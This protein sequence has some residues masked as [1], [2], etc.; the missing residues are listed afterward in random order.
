MTS[1]L[2]QVFLTC[3]YLVPTLFFDILW[4]HLFRLQTCKLFQAIL[5][6]L[7]NLLFIF[8]FQ[9]IKAFVQTF[10]DIYFFLFVLLLQ[11]LD[12]NFQVYH[13]HSIEEP[14]IEGTHRVNVGRGQKADSLLGSHLVKVHLHDVGL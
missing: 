12:L 9:L 11:I 8:L 3:L 13:S 1:D 4:Q 10:L 14:L 5:Q 7:L 6:L 2:I